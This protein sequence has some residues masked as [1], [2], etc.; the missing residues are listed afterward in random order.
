MILKTFKEFII[1]NTIANE[2]IIYDVVPIFN[3]L[4]ELQIKDKF[5]LYYKDTEIGK[6]YLYV[7]SLGDLLILNEI[8]INKEFRERGYATKFMKQ[9]IKLA[10]HM[11]IKMSLN[12]DN[13]KGSNKERLK[14]F[15]SRFGFC[16]NKGKDKDYSVS[17]LMIRLPKYQKASL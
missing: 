3:S 8:E 4:G 14:K 7:R 11:Q 1:E 16:L 12:P 9:L 10:D 15:Y 6:A 2:N 5:H 13:Y 17:E